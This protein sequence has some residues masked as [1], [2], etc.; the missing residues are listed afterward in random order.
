[1]IKRFSLTKTVMGKDFNFEFEK[2]SYL[3]K[4]ANGA[5]KTTVLS[6]L[7]PFDDFLSKDRSI[8]DLLKPG[9][10]KEIVLTRF[11][12]EYL[13]RIR[14]KKSSDD[15]FIQ[16][17]GEQVLLT[18]SVSIFKKEVDKIFN[19]KYFLFSQLHS[20]LKNFSNLQNSA[21]KN[22]FLTLAS[23]EEFAN[24]QQILREKIKSLSS[25]YENITHQLLGLDKGIEQFDIKHTEEELQATITNCKASLEKIEIMLKDNDSKRSQHIELTKAKNK[26]ESYIQYLISS[27]NS[28]EEKDDHVS[29]SKDKVKTYSENINRQKELEEILTNIQNKEYDEIAIIDNKI[30]E[31]KMKKYKLSNEIETTKKYENLPCEKSLQKKCP[32]VPEKLIDM[33]VLNA[34]MDKLLDDKNKLEAGKKAIKQKYANEREAFELEQRGLTK[35]IK[36]Q[37]KL[38][39]YIRFVEESS[40]KLEKYRKD[41]EESETKLK[42]IND[43]IE[44]VGFDSDLLMK[45][46]EKKINIT[47]KLNS[48]EQ[49]LKLI[50]IVKSSEEEKNSLR[51]MQEA[52]MKKKESFAKIQKLFSV[53]EFPAVELLSV[54]EQINTT[55]NHLLGLY[56]PNF[57]LEAHL[58]DDARQSIIL[59]VINNG[60]KLNLDDLSS[61]EGVWINKF[62]RLALAFTARQSYPYIDYL[63][64]DEGE[65]AVDQEAR[66]IFLASHNDMISKFNFSQLFIVSHDPRANELFDHVI[67][68]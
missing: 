49:E 13:I 18:T 4:G 2:G 58:K 16:K 47:N 3:I 48:S 64:C 52:I 66:E 30:N 68:F 25:K 12:D 38:L 67:T 53:N 45:L 55:T 44:E 22:M 62:I 54:L 9:G 50:K 5:G 8:R 42:E 65:G 41:L 31:L 43:K 14:K 29:N 26:E 19:R 35:E 15:F 24:I 28:I 39:E 27:I 33:K 59:D 51:E 57:R 36:E 34:R 56:N 1:M 60:T 32:L 46:T 7:H 23:G 61:G 40:A 37:E 21:I 20:N 11:S 17:N 10:K 63:T 6:S